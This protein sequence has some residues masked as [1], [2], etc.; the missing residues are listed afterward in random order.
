[1]FFMQFYDLRSEFLVS[2]LTTEN[3]LIAM[4][5]KGSE[6]KKYWNILSGF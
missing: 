4:I 1:M 3:R 2:T 5:R 6:S